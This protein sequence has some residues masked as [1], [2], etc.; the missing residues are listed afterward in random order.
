MDTF[1]IEGGKPLIGEVT[2]AGAKNVAVKAIV[3]SLL[4]DEPVMLFNMPHIH[5]VHLLLELLSKMGISY[6]WSDHELTITH[7]GAASTTVPLDLGA[8]IRTSAMLLG[9]LLSRFGDA[10][11]PNPGGCR[12]GARP[13]DRHID[14]L[15]SMGAQI[16]YNSDDG[17]FYAKAQKLHGAHIMFP[18]NTHTGTE[19]ILL[20][21]VLARGETQIDNAAEEVEVDDLIHLLVA[22]GAKITRPAPR[23]IVITG[24]NA[25]H[26][27]SFRIMPDRN[28][29]VT[30]AIAAAITGGNIT[31]HDSRREHLKTFLE[32]FSLAGG[33]ASPVSETETR[34]SL[35]TGTIRPTDVVTEPHPKFMTDWQGPW[36]VFMTQADGV[37]TLHETVFESRFSYVSELHKMGAK[38]EYYTPVISDPSAYYNFNWAD[39]SIDSQQAIRI[40]GKT[41][42]HNAVLSM[43]DLRAGATLVLAALT[44]KGKSYIHGVEQMDRGYEHIVERLTQLGAAVSRIKEEE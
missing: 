32:F 15:R 13:I 4:T 19:T 28:E 21:A 1:I 37:S 42:L 16:S 14:A 5:D 39:K 30:F 26:G 34:Y 44:A 7:M 23:K 41:E 22:M 17:Y 38:I 31:V 12:I 18:K 3:A 6:S 2:V 11:I 8:R 36:A 25:L 9:P 35:A 40:T 43:N 10:K 20:A 33:L 24:V 27:C 29:E